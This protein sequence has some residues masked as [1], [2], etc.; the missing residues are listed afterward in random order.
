MTTRLFQTVS[1]T[2]SLLAI[3][4]MFC[5]LTGCKGNAT[6]STAGD[7]KIMKLNH[8]SQYSAEQQ[9]DEIISECA[10]DASNA[11]YICFRN[12]ALAEKGVLA[13]QLFRYPQ[14]GAA[15]LLVDWNTSPEVSALLSD[16]YFT[17]GDIAASQHMAFESLVVT[18]QLQVKLTTEENPAMLKRLVQTNLIN[19]AHA[20]AE[21]YIKV[22]E[23]MG[24][25]KTWCNRHRSF[26]YDDAKVAA[27]PLLGQKRKCIPPENYFIRLGDLE[28]NWLTIARANPESRTA[29]H[30]LGS[31]YLLEKQLKK[32]RDLIEEN[33]PTEVLPTLPRSFQEAVIA[34]AEADTA[35]WHT[36]GVS[37][38]TVERFNR[39]KRT[40]LSNRGN[41][42]VS[43]IM[44][45]QFGD[46]FWYYLMFKN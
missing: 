25:H 39:Y 3:A 32:F 12:R 43:H 29:I 22:L 34:T 26:L 30:Y 44:R 17:I 31:M 19:G 1:K 37:A 23:Q 4:T 10:A 46:T 13:E 9:W 16:V 42:N 33:Y 8:L 21:K 35:Y 2:V 27:D 14:C 20:V 41:P 7:P 40:L 36:H 24:G 18:P 11:L 38:S 6:D 5:S 28:K 45:Q 15:G